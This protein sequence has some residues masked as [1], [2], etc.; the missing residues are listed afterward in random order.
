MGKDFG[1]K[2]QV[3]IEGIHPQNPSGHPLGSKKARDVGPLYR[4]FHRLGELKKIQ[5]SSKVKTKYYKNN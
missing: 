3:C 2:I 1:A 5:S 4:L